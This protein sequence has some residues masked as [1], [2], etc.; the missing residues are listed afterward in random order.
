MRSQRLIG[1]ADFSRLRHRHDKRDAVEPTDADASLVTGR[2][3]DESVF[4]A[5]QLATFRG[6]LCAE[7]MT[8][9]AFS[10]ERLEVST[11]PADQDQCAQ[12]SRWLRLTLQC[13]SSCH[14]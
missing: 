1:R 5:F 11:E 2:A 4:T 10:V 14:S 7:P 8:G 9:L 13:G 12:P 3:F 6:P